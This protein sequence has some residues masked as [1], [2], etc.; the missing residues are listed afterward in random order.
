[1]AAAAPRRVAELTDLRVRSVG[2]ICRTA[3]ACAQAAAPLA[4]ATARDVSDM[5]VRDRSWRYRA[6]RRPTS[7]LSGVRRQIQQ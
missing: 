5:W 1:M 3:H 7:D 6:R 2:N 4:R